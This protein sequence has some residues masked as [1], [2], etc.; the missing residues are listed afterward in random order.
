[1][2]VGSQKPFYATDKL[3]KRECGSVACCGTS[4]VGRGERVDKIWWVAHDDIETFLG[5]K[6]LQRGVLNAYAAVPGRGF[7]I[8]ACL[9]HAVGIN[10][11]SGNM[12]LGGA[13]GCHNGYQTASCAYIKDRAS[14]GG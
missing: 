7:G 11:Y 2:S 1:M 12:C 4:C 6:L 3:L 10:I 9:S 8:E 5:S 13:L 14:G